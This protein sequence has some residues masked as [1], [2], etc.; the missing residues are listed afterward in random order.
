MNAN[1]LPVV[2]AGFWRRVLAGLIDMLF[3]GLVLVLLTVA[4]GMALGLTLGDSMTAREL[5]SLWE[6]GSDGLTLI[7]V[8]LW[9]AW[10][11]S[12]PR[13]ATVGKK[14][15]G[16]KVTD[17][18]GGRIGFGRASWRLVAKVF[19]AL[20][21]GAGFVM[22]AFTRRRQGLHDRMAGTLV[23]RAEGRAYRVGAAST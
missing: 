17:L 9:F 4:L 11:E 20:P 10:P 19:S 21:L 7:V 23:C 14:M 22:V 15:L 6:A 5:D 8:W 12:R 13:Q 1:P 3:C 16:L 2:P 18:H